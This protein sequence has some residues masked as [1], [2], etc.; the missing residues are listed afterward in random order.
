STEPTNIDINTAQQRVVGDKRYELSNHLGNV[1]ATISDRKLPEF[2]LGE[3]LAYY[4]PD[5]VSYSDYMP[6]GM[7]MAERNGSAGDYRY[8]YQG[9]EKDDE[10][11]GSGNSYTTHFRQLDPRIGRWLSLDPK[12][13]AWENPYASMGNNPIFHNDVYGDTVA[14]FNSN[15]SFKEF[16]DDGKT[17]WTWEIGSN[18][19]SNWVSSNTGKFNDPSVDVTAIKNF[20]NSDGAVGIGYM[21]V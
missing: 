18:D 13:S 11:K 4:K 7:Q 5:V 19:G 10:I 8:G 12:M 1:L 15:G 17:D 20:V 6:F 14:R 21:V 2:D 16:F 3:G 9:S